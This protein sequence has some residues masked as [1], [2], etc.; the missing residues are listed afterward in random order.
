MKL[1][2]VVGARPQFVKAAVVSRA[3]RQHN[4][5]CPAGQ[6]INEIIVHSGQH[7]D[8]NMSDIF[9]NEMNIPR[10]NHRLQL[11]KSGHGGMTG[12]ILEGVEQII[13][14]EKPDIVLVY[15]DTNTTLA[16][17]LAAVKL[18]IAVAHVEAGLRSFNM[19]M[20]EEINRVVTD[21]V[22]RWLFCPTEVAMDN[23]AREGFDKAGLRKDDVR[24]SVENVG[25]VMLDAA[26]YYR[27]K[28]V[29]TV[30]TSTLIQKCRHSYYLATVHRA[31]NTDETTRLSN[32]ISALDEIG[33]H[34]PVILPLH[35]RTRKILADQGFLP[36]NIT[37]IDPVGY[38]DM[39]HLLSNCR[40]VFT[41]SGGL[42]KEAYFFAKPCVTLRDETEWTELVAGGFNILAGADYKRILAAEKTMTVYKPDYTAQLY[43]DGAAS[44]KIVDA[45]VAADCL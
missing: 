2:T 31:E 44:R 36:R 3:I 34:T 45:L 33:S 41:D 22:S 28:A 42:Q 11:T 35:P 20:P 43:G 1:L 23:L 37:I 14:E 40:C 16:G 30:A 15:G 6:R 27:G 9:F 13:I 5:T 39:L 10:P 26:L 18:H 25:D 32:I 38:F 24:V 21:R 19:R 29:A 8:L 17:A 12:E 7:Y 4:K